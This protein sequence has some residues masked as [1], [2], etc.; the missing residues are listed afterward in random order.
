MIMREAERERERDRVEET[1]AMRT[2]APKLRRLERLDGPHSEGDSER[3]V[4]MMARLV[5]ARGVGDA[6]LGTRR[7]ER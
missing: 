4:D 6:D 2:V 3:M 7:F 1:E 5:A